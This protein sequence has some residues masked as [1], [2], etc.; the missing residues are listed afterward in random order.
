MTS[1]E[2]QISPEFGTGAVDLLLVGRD[3]GRKGVEKGKPFAN[4][5]KFSGAAYIL[6][7]ALAEAGIRR[8][9]LKAITNVV[10]R[11][12]KGN[13]FAAHGKAAIH[14]GWSDLKD[15]IE[16]M[17]PNCVVALG[18]IASY[19][20]IP[21][22]PTKENRPDEMR[23]AKGIQSRRG[24]VFEGRHGGKVLTTVHPSSVQRGGW[25]P[26]RMLLTEDFQQAK[27]E[28]QFPEFDWPEYD[29]T[30]LTTKGE[31]DLCVSRI[32]Q[33]DRVSCDIELWPDNSLACVGFG[34]SDRKAFVFPE[35]YFSQIRHLLEEER[36]HLIG[37]NFQFDKYVLDSRRGVTVRGVSDDTQVAWH[38]MYP[39]LAGASEQRGHRMSRKGLAFIASLYTRAPWW[40]EDYETETEFFEY[41]GADC[42]ITYE[43]MQQLDDEI[44]QIGVRG[45]YEHMISLIPVVTAMQRR[46]LV[47]DEDLLDERVAKLEDRYAELA[48]EINEMVKP[49]IEDRRERIEEDI[50]LFRRGGFETDTGYR[51]TC[52]CCN[53]GK[54]KSQSCTNC[55][56]IEGSGANGAIVKSDLLEWASENMDCPG[57]EDFTKAE[58]RALV[59]EC[60]VCDGDG[61]RVETW[62]NPTSDDQIK[63]ILYDALKA[64]PRRKDG[65]LTTDKIRLLNLAAE[66]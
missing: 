31:A 3:L 22:W 56:G 26:W 33:E 14:R 62:M 40:K 57:W 16:E 15:L 9:D 12:P 21:D 2:P 32:E 13:V 27:R 49:V 58:L 60:S 42:C 63:A 17:D 43:C 41:N 66:L 36:P 55:A 44:D 47:V 52:P 23:Y 6:N 45:I 34:V 8:Q 37:A 65:S 29:V 20:L 5:S 35:K 50:H 24:Y 18:N 61:K 30:I 1:V 25:I 38:A 4:T 28:A 7:K 59:P 54:K 53:G 11:R 48:A 46:G 10:M 64:P 19:A 51:E 39:S